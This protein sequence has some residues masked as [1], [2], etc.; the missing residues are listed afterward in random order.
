MDETGEGMG[1]DDMS[2]IGEDFEKNEEDVALLALT[3]VGDEEVGGFHDKGEEELLSAQNYGEKEDDLVWS[4]GELEMEGRALEF[5]LTKGV[6]GP[7]DTDHVLG[8]EGLTYKTKNKGKCILKEAD[9]VA[10]GNRN[11]FK[12]SCSRKNFGPDGLNG[13]KSKFVKSTK[14][15]KGENGALFSLNPLFGGLTKASMFATTFQEG[16]RWRKTTK[17]KKKKSGR[18][19]ALPQE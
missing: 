2:I 3:W 8:Q 12:G 17:K 19:K 16:P 9:D 5:Q 14:Q 1:E 13:G 10:M 15:K 11:L 7:L 18:T 4:R 6:I